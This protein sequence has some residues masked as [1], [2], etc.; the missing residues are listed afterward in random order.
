MMAGR[1]SRQ[2]LLPALLLIFAA[3][4]LAVYKCESNG[5]ASYSDV[6]CPG[7][8]VIDLGVAPPD[9]VAAARHGLAREKA[10]A[11]RLE[12]ARHAREAKEEKAK[13]RIARAQ[14]IKQKKCATLALHKK[15]ADEDARAAT[16]KSVL[17][18]RRKARHADERYQQECEF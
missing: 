8:R 14:A 5:K 15:W 6:P 13:K 1:R 2:I 16:G 9:D 7:G 18:I 12:K 4:A 3:P 17:K 10:E 11:D